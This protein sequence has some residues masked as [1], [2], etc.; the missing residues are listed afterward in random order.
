MGL[1]RIRHFTHVEENFKRFP[2]VQYGVDV[3]QKSLHIE[4]EIGKAPVKLPFMVFN[5]AIK[6]YGALINDLTLHLR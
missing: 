6:A 2:A 1:C 5:K 3:I 4:I